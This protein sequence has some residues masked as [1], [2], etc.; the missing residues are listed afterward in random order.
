MLSPI[1][2]L[3]P[4]ILG[5][6]FSLVVS[7]MFRAYLP[8]PETQHAPWLLTRVCRHWSAVALANPAL[9]STVFVDLDCVERQG[10][11]MLTELCLQRAENVSLTV[12]IFQEYGRHNA[13]VGQA[14]DAVLS[15][16]NR[17]KTAHFHILSSFAETH[18]LLQRLSNIHRFSNL[19]TLRVSIGLE[20]P[21]QGFDEACWSVFADLPKLRSLEARFWDN[22]FLPPPFSVQWHQLTRVSTTF[23]SN[24]ETLAALRE[25]A[26]IVECTFNFTDSL[27][28]PVD[29]KPIRLPHLRS[30]TL[31]IDKYNAS[32]YTHPK[33]TSLL[34][35]LET[36]CLRKLVTDKTPAVEDVLGL[37]TSHVVSLPL[38][39]RPS[40]HD[41]AGGAEDA[42]SHLTRIR[43]LEGGSPRFSPSVPEP[44]AERHEGEVS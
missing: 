23:C 6:I 4:E 41:R 10:T 27:V 40:R 44:V 17:W 28:L 15:I 39:L 3:P 20:T 37:V 14:L 7:T 36:P 9:W 35:F 13:H 8:P 42:A 25:M 38:G 21:T 5:E 30:L 31:L 24:A 34:D 29:D 19:T 11:V 26:D 22:T 16:S 43:R 1:R 33:H 32:A 18:Q 12:G 2:R